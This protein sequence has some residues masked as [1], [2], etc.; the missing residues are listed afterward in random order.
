MAFRLALLFGGS[1]LMLA[2]GL[3]LLLVLT[4]LTGTADIGLG[5]LGCACAALGRA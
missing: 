3:D 4:P 2:C 1:L 5:F